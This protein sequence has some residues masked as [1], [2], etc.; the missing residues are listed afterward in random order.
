MLDIAG[1]PIPEGQKPPSAVGK[2]EYPPWPGRSLLLVA[3]SREIGTSDAA[4]VEDDQDDLGFRLRTLVT[5][6]YRL[7]AYSGQSYGELFDLQED[8]DEVHNLWDQPRHARLRDELR[9]RP[10][11]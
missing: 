5:Q 6:R 7:T 9:H 1:V 3:T 4:L 10:S 8:P 2:W 11:G